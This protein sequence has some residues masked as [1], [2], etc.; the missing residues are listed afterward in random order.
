MRKI[1][2]D[3][4]ELMKINRPDVAWGLIPFDFDVAGTAVDFDQ[5]Q[6]TAIPCFLRFEGCDLDLSS[7]VRMKL[8]WCRPGNG[9]LTGTQKLKRTTKRLGFSGYACSSPITRM[10]HE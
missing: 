1:D 9:S 2:I 4:L 3:R 5:P 10:R 7:A 6:H 8:E